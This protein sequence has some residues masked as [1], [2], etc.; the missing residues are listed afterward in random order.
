MANILNWPDL[1]SPQRVNSPQA[2]TITSTT[3]GAERS[4]FEADY[5]RVVFCEP[6]RRLARKTQVHPLAPN[7]HIHNRLIHSIEVGSVGRSLAKKIQHFLCQQ[8]P[9]HQTIF[10]DIPQ[11]IQVG[12]LVH[13]IGNPPFG[14]AGEFSIRE[15]LATHQQLVFNDNDGAEL[16]SAETRNDLLLFEGNAQGFRLAARHD[17]PQCGYMRLSYASLGAMIKYP[18]SS[19]D[20][21]AQKKKKFNIFASESK[22]FHDMA[23]TMGLMRTDGSVSRHPLSFLSE[24]A[25]DICYRMLDME[26]AVSMR[27][28]AAINALINEAVQVFCADY[29]NIMDGNRQQDL[30]SDFSPRF[31]SAFADIGE[32]YHE[33]FS[34]RGKLG[35]EIGSYKIVGRIIKAFVLAIKSLCKKG[36]Y[37]AI[38]FISQRCLDLAWDKEYI[39]SNS[40]KS[41]EW[42]LRQVFDFVSGLTDNYAIQI[43]A[44]IEGIIPS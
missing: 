7:D 6:F 41:Y 9:Q 32:L 37:D 43:S 20:S 16:C 11:I 30:K 3:T 42:W 29:Q 25:D 33:I 22:I 12:C 38:E 44:E 13:D 21:L 15:W 5:D 8:Q 28:G 4:A 24:A 1:L 17:N 27:I 31:R 35:Y 40:D 36:D 26:D 19:S 18:W 10:A 14:H 23:T 2:P 39:R 34:H